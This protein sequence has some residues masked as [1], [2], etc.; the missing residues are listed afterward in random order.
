MTITSTYY[1]DERMSGPLFSSAPGH[2]PGHAPTIFPGH[3]RFLPGAPFRKN[4]T[5]RMEKGDA[6]TVTVTAETECGGRPPPAGQTGRTAYSESSGRSMKLS[7]MHQ[8]SAV[9]VE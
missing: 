6:V 4:Q 2:A 9:G 5:E 3:E 8:A 1:G 7:A